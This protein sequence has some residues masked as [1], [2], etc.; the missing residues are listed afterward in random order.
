M[1]CVAC[2]D[3]VRRFELP[4]KVHAFSSNVSHSH[5]MPRRGKKAGDRKVYSRPAVRYV[6]KSAVEPPV[7]RNFMLIEFKL[8]GCDSF[9]YPHHATE[10]R[11]AS[12]YA[13]VP[14]ENY[15]LATR[16]KNPRPK[17]RSRIIS[18]KLGIQ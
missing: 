4:K 18:R 2:A 13:T 6:G 12:S 3:A 16:E 5:L 11:N 9:C 15:N 8:D 17:T 7:G 1:F 10:A 14:P